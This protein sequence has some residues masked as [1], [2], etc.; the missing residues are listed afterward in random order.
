MLALDTGTAVA[1]AADYALQVEPLGVDFAHS[2]GGLG[3]DEGPGDPH[4]ARQ[5]HPFVEGLGRHSLR[6]FQ[7]LLVP[8]Q[9]EGV[10]F[11]YLSDGLR[12][13]EVQVDLVLR[14][15]RILVLLRLQDECLLEVA[16]AAQDRAQR[17]VPVLPLKKLQPLVS[18]RAGLLLHLQARLII[19]V[20]CK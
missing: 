7:P 15:I 4:G 8:L 19:A 6:A 20:V 11:W 2:D 3:R 12:L 13:K 18:P 14:E 17:M 10:V 5:V 1:L 9:E 16:F